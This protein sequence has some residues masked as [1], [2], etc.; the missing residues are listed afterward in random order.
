M[1]DPSRSSQTTVQQERFKGYYMLT[2]RCNLSCG[3][4]VLENAPHQLRA[5]L[6]LE[7][8]MALIDHLHAQLGFRRLTLSGGEALLIG[9][10]PP[11]EFL[12]LLDFLRGFRSGVPEEDLQLELY[13]NGAL[14]DDGVA[15][16][17]A[18]VVDTVA[19]TIDSCDERVLTQLGRSTTRSPGYYRRAVEACARLAQRNVELKLHSVVAQANHARLGDEVRAIHEALLAA[20]A[21]PSKWKFYQYMSYDDAGHDGTNAIADDAFRRATEH[22]SRSLEGTNIDLHF[23]DNQEMNR[24][25]FNILPYG[26]AQ[27][28]REGDSWST[29]RRTGDL[30]G[31]GSMR[32]LFSA[33]DID[34][35]AFRRCHEMPPCSVGVR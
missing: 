15:D 5:E 28:M 10:R 11:A 16:A 12:Q 30:R 19:M 35:A 13:T 18:G 6:N 3:Y 22:I 2:S 24:S 34:E 21:R 9:K 33:C 25:L 26:N 1:T 17:L 8:K 23:K 29:T 32:E 20:K 7:G 31:Y 27:Y 14:L 4:C